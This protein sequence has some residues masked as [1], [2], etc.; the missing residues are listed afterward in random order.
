MNTSRS[1]RE[2]RQAFLE[3]F[4]EYGHTQVP[5]ASLVPVNN[6]TL[7]FTNAGMVPFVETF[8]GLEQRPYKRATTSQKC[9]RVSGKH[10]DLDNVGPSPRHHTFF[11]MLGNFSFGDYFKRDAIRFAWQLL[12]EVF[13]LPK[14]RLWVTVFEG[15]ERVAPD[16]EAEQL[17]REVGVA[18]S[19]ILR[20]GEKD[21][22][23]Q[24]G[25]TGPCGPCSEIHYYQGDHPERQVPEGVNSDD[26]DYMEIWNLVFMQYEKDA[27]GSLTPLPKPS[28][29]TGMGFERITAVLQGVRNNYHTDLFV[30]IVERLVALVGK[31]HSHYAGNVAPYHAIADHSRACAFLIA[32]GVRPGNEGRSYVLRRILR[33][34][35]YQGYTLDLKRPFLAETAAVVIETMGDAYPELARRREYILQT[36]T[37]E[38]ERFSRTLAD[39]IV[40]L[41]AAVSRMREAGETT[42]SGRDVFV[43]YSTYGFPVDLTERILEA[44]GLGYDAD[45]YEAEMEAFRQQARDSSKFK[46]TGEAE[47]WAEHGLPASSFLG[48]TTTRDTG[49]VQALV[50][51]G[52]LVNL[53]AQGQTVQIVLDR[54]PFYAE[55]GGQVGDTG[56]LVGPNGVV[57]VSD[58]QRPLAGLIVHIGTVE[59]GEIATGDSVEAS[60]DA[61]RRADIMRNHTA[62]HL[63]H[64]VLHQLVGEHATQAGSLVAPDRLRFDFNHGKAIGP[65]Q[66]REISRRVNAWIREDDAVDWRISSYQDAIGSGAMAL[67]GEKYGDEVR[68]VT[69]GC[70][71]DSAFCS[72]ELCG[73]TH[74]GRTGEI[75]AFQ[76][77]SEGS[78]GAGIRRIEAV[79]GRGV[80]ELVEANLSSLRGAA[81]KLNVAPAGVL[82]RI[83]ALLGELKA[84]QKLIETLQGQQARGA[85]DAVLQAAQDHNGF[86]YVAARVEAPDSAR[87]REMGDWLRDK[88]GEGVVVLGA[89]LGGKPQLLAM[90]TPSLVKQG[91]NAGALVRELAQ[92]V[93]GGGGGRPELAQ[94]GGKDPEKLDEAIGRVAELLAKQG[95]G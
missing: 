44:Q 87:L 77:V 70:D 34:A 12:T 36:I 4:E 53:A 30:P 66:L 73:G 81:E 93:G 32:D 8:L 69:V 43:L 89:L 6:P 68:M 26:D 10:N 95:K 67:F 75:G 61:E 23:W 51:D 55:S 63:L 17:W 84:S 54:T 85:L 92:V 40:R 83:D 15:N 91:Y 48:Y 7:L 25:E 1:S 86:R 59:S 71:D 56:T 21:N 79:T 22:F 37:E 41:D 42:L 82:A 49:N 60:V 24:M 14:D 20:F 88:L 28:I 31:G 62:T 29:D 72:R 80:E 52:E 47:A 35:A 57:R 19:R 13:G 5:S 94:A 45:G 18:P 3:F 16:E 74:V 46:R 27:E 39:G 11:E 38:E 90:V 76:I 50:V 2:I 58:T 78:V 9:M 33:R 65:E 64:K